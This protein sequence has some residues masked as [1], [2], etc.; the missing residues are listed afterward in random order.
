MS[1]AT[2]TAS[3]LS[4]LPSIGTSGSNGDGGTSRSASYFFGFLVTFA[5]LLVLFVVAGFV[6][7]HRM[8]ARRRATTLEMEIGAG[9]TWVYGYR[10][11]RMCEEMR[12]VR[13]VWMER[14]I[15]DPDTSEKARRASVDGG[16]GKWEDIL[17]LSATLTHPEQELKPDDGAQAGEEEKTRRTSS[18]TISSWFSSFSTPKTTNVVDPSPSQLPVQDALRDPQTGVDV[19]VMI[20]MPRSPKSWGYEFGVTNVPL[21]GRGID[22]DNLP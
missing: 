15:E 20:A 13:P 14:W 7:R 3:A 9:D 1:T 10:E 8:R 5:V 2:S 17:P 16:I 18:S 19:V 21:V 4:Q 6:S 22:T 11:R 12:K